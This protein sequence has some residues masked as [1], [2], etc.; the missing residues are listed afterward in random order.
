MGNN[1]CHLASNSPFYGDVNITWR[2]N[3]IR[4]SRRCQI[5]TSKILK[6]DAVSVSLGGSMENV[7]ETFKN[8]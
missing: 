5:G 2:R 6:D 3:M 4:S 8:F 1:E 7:I